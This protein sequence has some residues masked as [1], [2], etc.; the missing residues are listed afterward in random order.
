MIVIAEG[1][2]RLLLDPEQGMTVHSLEYKGQELIHLDLERR[3]TGA[4]YGIPILFPTPN[5]VSGDSYMYGGK[6]VAAQMHGFLRHENFEVIEASDTTVSGKVAF[7]G[8]YPM[9]PY[10]GAFDLSLSVKDDAVTWKFMVTNSG[11][12]AFSYGLAIH[13]FFKKE[14]GMQFTADFSSLMV[15]GDDRIPNGTLEAVAGTAMDF[16]KGV[17]V[18]DINMDSMFL[19]NGLL[20]SIIGYK[21]FSVS[22]EGSGDFGHAVV[23]TS[24]D[25]PFFCLEP[26]TCS[27]DAHNLASKGFQKEASLVVV[28]PFSRHESF[29]CIRFE[30]K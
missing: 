5:R 6:S 19:T 1:E 2:T 21:G 3:A 4:T 15:S 23:Y 28:E 20:H 25:K 8:S 10:P 17:P 18:K 9:F 27:T 7:D 29:V 26:H 16:R 22:I 11:D 24:P 12:E 14:E 30:K 13:P